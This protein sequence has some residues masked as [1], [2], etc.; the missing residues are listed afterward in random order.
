MKDGWGGG[1][2]VVQDRRGK[3]V[4]R[5]LRCHVHCQ[6]RNIFDQCIGVEILELNGLKCQGR[7]DHRKAGRLGASCGASRG[8]NQKREGE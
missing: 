5:S 1:T 8:S 2:G 3:E 4:R 6:G 7:K